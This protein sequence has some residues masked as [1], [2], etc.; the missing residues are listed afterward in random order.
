MSAVSIS[1]HNSGSCRRSLPELC[2][3]CL[4]NSALGGYG[5]VLQVFWTIK[6]LW[7]LFCVMFKID[8][9]FFVKDDEVSFWKRSK[10]VRNITSAVKGCRKW[11]NGAIYLRKI[12]LWN[13]SWTGWIDT[14]D[15]QQNWKR[16]T[17]DYR[18]WTEIFYRRFE[19]SHLRSLWTGFLLRGEAGISVVRGVDELY[20]GVRRGEGREKR[21]DDNDTMSQL[22]LERNTAAWKRRRRKQLWKTKPFP[23]SGYF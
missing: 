6:K 22:I 20:L 10:S 15:N 17:A 18:L 4:Q 11:G 5:G 8:S 12:W 14:E 19:Y 9:L 7:C 1:R 3:S 13:C 21:R 2:R 23:C 16:Q